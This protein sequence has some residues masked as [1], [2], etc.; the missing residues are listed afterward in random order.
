MT[1]SDGSVKG[2]MGAGAM[3]QDPAG[4]RTPY[5]V[6]VGGA[7]SSFRA[8]AA[9]M[10]LAIRH[11]PAGP[12]TVLTD[13]MNVIYALRA[14]RTKEFARDMNQQLNADIIKDILYMINQRTAAT[15]LVK[16]KS[17]RGVYLN[18]EADKQADAAATADAKEGVPCR[19]ADQEPEDGFVWD[20]KVPAQTAD[21]P[22]VP[23]STSKHS[24]LFKRWRS[25]ADQQTAKQVQQGGTLGGT[26]MLEDYWGHQLWHKSHLASPWTAQQRR[27]WM[28]HV[29]RTFPTYSYLR[30]IDK[31]PTGMCPWGCKVSETQTHFQ[32]VCPR[33]RDNSIAAHH[34]IARAVVITL[35]EIK[36]AGW[37]ILY[38]T[39]FKDMPFPIEWASPQEAAVQQKRRPDAVAWD[40]SS[41][42]VLILEFTRA[43]D[44]P[45]TMAAA[46][47][48]KGTQ[49][50]EAEQGI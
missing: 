15:H 23:F 33:F 26:F 3:L 48:A 27:R 36:P 37:Q 14:F 2:D 28:Q 30:R 18:E 22:D 4:N 9:A 8:E 17:H 45:E 46:L 24:E 47:A 11:A 5:A 29:G 49:Y 50:L 1:A 35:K 13:L 16:I 41:K 44:A 25:Q 19:Y 34:L 21:A 20:W 38:E 32:S 10:A 12:L 7:F 43:M 6:K 40:P 31:H 42:T 39:D